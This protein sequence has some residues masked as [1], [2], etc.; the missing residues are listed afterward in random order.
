MNT[1]VIVLRAC[2]RR[3]ESPSSG[4]ISA[5]TMSEGTGNGSAKYCA[6]TAREKSAKIGTAACVPERFRPR[7]SS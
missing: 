2:R 1:S 5:V 3:R 4:S 6:G 7:L